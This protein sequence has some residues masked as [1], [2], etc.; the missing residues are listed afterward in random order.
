LF[1]ARHLLL[2][3]GPLG[4]R[5]NN[6]GLSLANEGADPTSIL[7]H[8]SE[9][10]SE[11]TMNYNASQKFGSLSYQWA[12]FAETQKGTV[13]H[14]SILPGMSAPGTMFSR[15]LPATSD[16]E[17]LV[18]IS[19]CESEFVVRIELVGVRRDQVRV[20]LDGNSPFRSRP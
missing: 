4:K 13:L 10:E 18:D 9:R 17:P 3:R 19:E 12:P 5:C 8:V 6:A 14:N 15:V 7:N 1:N 11:V 16:W 2:F 20:K